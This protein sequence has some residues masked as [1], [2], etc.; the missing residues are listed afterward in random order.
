M[1]VETTKNWAENMKD[2][3]LACVPD[4]I[5]FSVRQKTRNQYSLIPV[6]KPGV[7]ASD[8]VGD[9]FGRVNKS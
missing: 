6:L 1:H 9:Q 2:P 7:Q 5:A 3:D 4:V 8:A